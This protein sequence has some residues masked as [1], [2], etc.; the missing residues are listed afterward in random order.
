MIRQ[1][2]ECFIGQSKTDMGVFFKI[3]Y[4]LF[5]GPQTTPKRSIQF[6]SRGKCRPCWVSCCIGELPVSPEY[7]CEMG[8]ITDFI[9]CLNY[10]LTP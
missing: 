1:W 4:Y 10:I 2:K 8:K 5:G 6:Q 9:A 7:Y 3:R